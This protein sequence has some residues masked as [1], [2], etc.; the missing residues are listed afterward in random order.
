VRSIDDRLY[1]GNEVLTLRLSNPVNAVLGTATAD[2]IIVENDPHDTTGPRLGIPSIEP[3]TRDVGIVVSTCP[4]QKDLLTFRIAV[5]DPSG[6]DD[7]ELRYLFTR[8]EIVRL[9]DE[10][11]ANQAV[12]MRP[13]T[14]SSIY[15]A[16]INGS[17]VIEGSGTFSYQIVATDNV[18]NRSEAQVYSQNARGSCNIVR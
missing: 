17:N 14:S 16:V 11:N 6:V 9:P 8:G 10:L 13:G 1:E 15:E 4:D 5:S 7:V 18:G 2:L 3:E 12:V